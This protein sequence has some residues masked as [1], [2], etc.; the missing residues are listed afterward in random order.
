MPTLLKGLVV[1]LTTAN[2]NNAGTDDQLYLGVIGRGG[3][4]EFPLATPEEDFE[5]QPPGKPEA[6]LLGSFWDNP[7]A[8]QP[9]PK[10]PFRSGPGG[11]ND[12][13]RF[14]VDLDMLDY[15][16]LRKQGDRGVD[17]SYALEQ[18]VVYLYGPVVGQRRTFR[19]D[20][21]ALWLGNAF[22]HVAYLHDVTVPPPPQP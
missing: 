8:N 3:G 5:V 15:V 14:E 17:D 20:N 19:C 21:P 13:A 18:V 22:G 16:Y 6:F 7:A 9:N 4:R 11:T 12:P 2:R 10:Y 1:I